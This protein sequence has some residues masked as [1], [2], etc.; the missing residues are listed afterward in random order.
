[1][2]LI[3]LQRDHTL[4]TFVRIVNFSDFSVAGQAFGVI[5]I[6]NKCN[7]SV[8][9]INKGLAAFVLDEVINA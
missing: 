9:F 5:M 2:I 1:M 6:I 7:H 4:V 8:V 3:F